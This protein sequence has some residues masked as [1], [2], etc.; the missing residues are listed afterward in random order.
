M[1]DFPWAQLPAL[2]KLELYAYGS[3]VELGQ[4]ALPRLRELGLQLGE[5]DARVAR[6]LYNAELPA[7]ERFTLAHDAGDDVDTELELLARLLEAPWMQ[8]LQ[9]LHL[10][11]NCL[12]RT[13]KNYVE[14]VLASPAAAAVEHLDL[15]S[16]W[17]QGVASERL[18]RFGRERRIR[19]SG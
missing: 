11:R 19:V 6:A 3:E 2:D 14:C 16:I 10:S 4:L 1:V 15:S 7:I 18:R 13:G 12:I 17:L 8:S 5:L 9:A